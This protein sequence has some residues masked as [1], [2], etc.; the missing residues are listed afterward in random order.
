MGDSDHDPAPWWGILFPTGGAPVPGDGSDFA[1]LTA[2]D[3]RTLAAFWLACD[4]EKAR[5]GP[6]WAGELSQARLQARMYLTLACERHGLDPTALRVQTTAGRCEPKA[7]ALLAR[8]NARLILGES[9]TSTET[10]AED[11]RE[12]P[13]PRTDEGAWSR[14]MSKTQG[15]LLLKMTRCTFETL[16]RGRIKA[17]G[18]QIFTFCID[19]LGPDQR[20]ALA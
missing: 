3:L 8:L 12:A 19:H 20:K 14:P 16:M 17:H 10:P 4:M 15:R 6:E 2:R 5:A 11:A 9:E 7:A 18:R 13:Q 1:R